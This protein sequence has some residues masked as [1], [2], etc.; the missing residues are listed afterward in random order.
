MAIPSLNFK[1]MLGSLSNSPKGDGKK[2]PSAKTAQ[3]GGGVPQYSYNNFPFDVK[4][5]L[6]N[7]VDTVDI[8]PQAIVYLNI[9][10]SLSKWYVE[11]EIAL[12]YS[13]D[14]IENA[15]FFPTG[16]DG[17]FGKYV[18]RNDG[19]DFLKISIK[20]T[21]PSDKN[22]STR[23]VVH[24][25]YADMPQHLLHLNLWMSIYRVQD[26]LSPFAGDNE[27]NILKYKKFYFRDYRYQK[28]STTI[29]EYSTALSPNIVTGP[30]VVADTARS[31]PTSTILHE[32][33]TS[34]QIDDALK[35][36]AKD[37]KPEEWD[38]SG[39]VLFYTAGA[40]ETIAD[41]I[42]YVLQRH[43]S[44]EGFSYPM[45]IPIVE[46]SSGAACG[47]GGT[48]ANPAA[49][50]TQAGTPSDVGGGT[51]GALAAVAAKDIGLHE[52][53]DSNKGPDIQKFFDASGVPPGSYWCAAACSYW[54]QQWIKGNNIPNVKPP[55]EGS[56]FQW[57]NWA[58]QNK[59][60]VSMSPSPGDVVVFK[61]SH[62][63]VVESVN[64]S[65]FGNISGNTSAGPGVERNGGGVYRKNSNISSVLHFIKT[66]TLG[67]QASG[68]A[69]PTGTGA[70]GADKA[71]SASSGGTLTDNQ[72]PTGA[73]GSTV[74]SGPNTGATNE[75]AKPVAAG[76]ALT[77][78]T[79]P[80][81]SCAPAGGSGGGGGG[82]GDGGISGSGAGG[83]A[84]TSGPNSGST[85][86]GGNPAK[87][88]GGGGA[89]TVGAD[90][91]PPNAAKT[92]NTA[93]QDP[94]ETKI[95]YTCYGGPMTDLT[96]LCDIIPSERPPE[97]VAKWGGE[98]KVNAIAA[99]MAAG[100]KAKPGVLH[101][102][103]AYRGCYGPLIMGKTIGSCRWPGGTVIKFTRQ[104]GSP[105]N[106]TG[107]NAEGVYTVTDYG[108]PKKN[109]TAVD[110]FTDNEKPFLKGAQSE[111]LNASVIT[112][113][114]K[115][116]PNY[117]RAHKLAASGEMPSEATAGKGSGASSNGSPDA[118]GTGGGG[119]KATPGSTANTSAG[120]GGNGA[121]GGPSG[122]GNGAPAPSYAGTNGYQDR[123]ESETKIHD[124]CLLTIN[125]GPTEADY[126]YFATRALKDYFKNAGKTSPGSLQMEHFY[127]QAM[128]GDSTGMVP[129]APRGTDVSK[130]IDVAIAGKSTIK[131]YK[132]VDISAEFNA[133]EFVSRPVHT[134][135]MKTR[136]YKVNYESHTVEMARKFIAEHYIKELF[137]EGGDDEE[138]FLVNINKDKKEKKNLRPVYTFLPDDSNVNQTLGIHKLLKSGIFQNACINFDIPGETYREPGTF[139]AIE[140]LEG[141]RPDS[142]FDTRFYGQWFIIKVLHYFTES[143][144]Y[145]NIT[146]VKIH[147][148][149]A[150][151][152]NFP[153]Y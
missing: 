45:H 81:A 23:G 111:L 99:K 74:T 67:T 88:G 86:A 24:D 151:K 76:P 115:T 144:Y 41:S 16:A 49:D 5:T 90:G 42:D 34:T 125:R 139:A 12:Q 7:G 1:Q 47:G 26:L 36:T 82:G 138:K 100:G 65:S 140:K 123:A 80:G 69:P 4:F 89:P 6:D 103:D 129:M 146:A 48:N 149:R 153:D 110:F 33:I 30:S 145:N 134:F 77:Q 133:Q 85:A 13:Y 56:C 28:M 25:K 124:V 97:A 122:G 50:S 78:P 109:F 150:I 75:A 71:A 58:K 32:L 63:G 84:I 96:T 118:N 127:V 29:A 17:G 83:G 53:G 130:L 142:T 57:Q 11:G 126:G 98:A 19:F 21:D 143:E 44:E 40:N 132:F 112:M 141:G 39:G 38:K 62:I 131:N 87:G 105:F 93:C 102:A 59:I 64:G 108:A 22:E 113:G 68:D 43:I 72:T 79:T 92:D 106:P 117:H 104:D 27:Q 107:I 54:V 114:S 73:A 128:V 61:A 51:N 136:N 121:A 147:R 3:S 37:V 94:R 18:F 31:I 135:N 2:S 70:P 120:G 10:D 35:K 60:P 15:H 8:N 101:L 116:G 55:R 52:I 46:T 66:S 137:S 91:L 20:P 152:S 95:Q 119:A 14:M 9:V 148:H